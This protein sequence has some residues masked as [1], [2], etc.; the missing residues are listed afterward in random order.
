MTK[1]QISS[2]PSRKTSSI[3][4]GRILGVVAIVLIF[5]LGG[6][7]FY[8]DSIYVSINDKTL[9]PNNGAVAATTV[10]IDGTEPLNAI[11]KNALM[12][13]L[14]KIQHDTIQYEI[15]QIYNITDLQDV[16]LKPVFNMCNPGSGKNMNSLYEN[17][18]LAK[19][20]WQRQFISP[21]E[22]SLG[23]AYMSKGYNHSPIMESIQSISGVSFGELSE[24][25]PKHLIIVSDMLQNSA[26]LSFYRNGIPSH[27]TLENSAFFAKI[28]TQYL[29]GVKVSLFLF[30]HPNISKR[31]RITHIEFWQNY[32]AKQGASIIHVK[33]IDG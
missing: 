22:Q 12:I 13:E 4:T 25:C 16:L 15:V 18:E 31:Q 7:Y 23:Q 32:F 20:R 10:I 17:P 3:G 8:L 6:V 26:G 21:L 30:R 2:V 14:K 5:I 1:K 28:R 24:T 27:T 33:V 19:K 9:C 29:K 11:Q